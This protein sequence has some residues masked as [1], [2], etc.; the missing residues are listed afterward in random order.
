MDKSL[1]F[2]LMFT[3]VFVAG[4]AADAYVR[5]LRYRRGRSGSR[6]R[7]MEQRLRSL[8]AVVADQDYELN[9]KLRRL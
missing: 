8:E 4:F 3:I 7:E 5:S 2:Y 6:E 1:A 9:Q